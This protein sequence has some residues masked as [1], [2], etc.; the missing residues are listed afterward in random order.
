M[1]TTPETLE[2]HVCAQGH[3]AFTVSAEDFIQ[4]VSNTET[5]SQLSVHFLPITD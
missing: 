1:S 3:Q 5:S 2:L 4:V